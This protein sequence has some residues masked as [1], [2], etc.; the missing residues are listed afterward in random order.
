MHLALVVLDKSFKMPPTLIVPEF[1]L[2][3]LLVFNL[4]LVW[5]TT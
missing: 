1:S 4:V 3:H 5:M 2:E